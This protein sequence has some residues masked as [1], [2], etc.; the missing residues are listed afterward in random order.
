[1]P[2]ERA[3]DCMMEVGAE[4]YGPDSLWEG[5]RTPGLVRFV[6]GEDFYLSP[7]N[8]GPV[9]Y[10]ALDPGLERPHQR[11]ALPLSYSASL[12]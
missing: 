9:M 4:I 11:A 3:G 1:M 2:L 5:F 7:S 10:G 12:T 6:T 8:G